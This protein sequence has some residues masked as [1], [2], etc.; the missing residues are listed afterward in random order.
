MQ[1]KEIGIKINENSCVHVIPR[2]FREKNGIQLIW[3]K[4][5]DGDCVQ[6][7]VF[8]S[9]EA[10]IKTAHAILSFFEEDIAPSA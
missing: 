7:R 10:A 5:K 4:D 1:A 3:K 8:L 2:R 9:E 6:T